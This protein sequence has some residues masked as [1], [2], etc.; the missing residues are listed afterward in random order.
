MN[1]L[2]KEEHEAVFKFHIK[3][4][5]DTCGKCFCNDL[6]IFLLMETGVA[7]TCKDFQNRVRQ[8]IE[9]ENSTI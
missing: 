4:H 3:N 2:T 9:R 7:T 6:C 1:K 5:P 8:V